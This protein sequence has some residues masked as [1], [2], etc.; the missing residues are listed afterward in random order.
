[1]RLTLI[2]SGIDP[3]PRADQGHHQFTYSLFPHEG[4]WF[5]AQTTQAAYE[6]NY[7]LLGAYANHSAGKLP[8]EG[9]LLTVDSTSAILDTVKK[10]EDGTDLVLRFYEFGNRRDHVRVEL[11]ETLQSVM[12]CNL[13][14][15]HD[16]PVQFNGN[17]FSFELKPYEIR[18]FKIK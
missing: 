2:K 6:L 5:A 14:E 8:V 7:E 15:Q 1:M 11:P 16:Q 17:T 4:D 12:E 18:T 13:M 9:R 3:D 10:S